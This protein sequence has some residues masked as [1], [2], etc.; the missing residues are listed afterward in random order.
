LSIGYP[1]DLYVGMTVGFFATVAIASALNKFGDAMFSK[2]V[3]RPFFVG[4][5]RVHHRSFLF[6]AVPVAYLAIAAMVL[7]GLVKIEWG[8]FWTGLAGTILVVADCL[9]VDLTFDYFHKGSGWGFL[10]HEIVY[11]AVPVYAFMAFLR[12][13]V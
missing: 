1:V 10:R 4:R 8:L 13:A 3:A 12:L 7:T 6:G 9:L 5:Y 11:V 2:G